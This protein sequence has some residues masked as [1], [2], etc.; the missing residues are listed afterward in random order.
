MVS[1]NGWAVNRTKLL[2]IGG[3]VHN[4]RHQKNAEH[5]EGKPE[6]NGGADQKANPSDDSGTTRT[7]DIAI[8]G[9]FAES[10][11]CERSDDQSG[12]S[13]K[14][15]GDCPDGRTGHGTLARAEPLHAERHRGDV[16][17][18]RRDRQ[19]AEND[20]RADA[21]PYKTVGPRC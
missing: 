12:N 3:S 17:D 9:E 10:R 15:S 6:L 1:A 14:Q 4:P 2:Q 16:D 21:N 8:G 18:V 20:D 11:A 5:G 13:E 19:D 7:T